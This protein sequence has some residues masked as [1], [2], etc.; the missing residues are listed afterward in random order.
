MQS[1]L[2]RHYDITDWAVFGVRSL[3][4]PGYV[5]VLGQDGWYTIQ[6]VHTVT[7]INGEFAVDTQVVADGQFATNVV[8]DVAGFKGWT[9]ETYTAAFDFAT[10][11][12]TADI[13]LYAWIEASAQGF[14]YPEGD[15][16]AT[17]SALYAWLVAN[18]ATQ[19]AINALGSKAALME[20][21]LLN[22]AL[23]D[24][25]Y[26]LKV[27]SIAVGETVDVAV[28][29]IRENALEGGIN[30]T[31]KLHGAAT[32]GADGEFAEVTGAEFVNGDFA[33]EGPAATSFTA[34]EAKFFKAV[35]E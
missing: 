32:L 30:G 15:A 34:G 29:L 21:Y 20:K 9:N 18:G 35:I 6:Q 5:P 10:T 17:D 28:T 26:E 31:L 3:C 11:A 22:L 24:S 25:S 16:I 23:A 12:I 13:T 8:L 14:N 4:A 33:K 2:Q 1:P 7:L 19:E 27:S